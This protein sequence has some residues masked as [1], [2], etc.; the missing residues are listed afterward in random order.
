VNDQFEFS[1]FNTQ[2]DYALALS[3]FTHLYL[4]HIQR[5]LVEMK[6]VLKPNG[7]FFATFF[8]SPLPAYLPDLHHTP[9]QVTTHYDHDPFHYSFVEMQMTAVHADL[10]V[11]LI[12]EFDHP[13]GQK[14][15]R[16][17]HAG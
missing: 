17:T 6:K 1:S 7:V 12:G 8:Q 11:E 5:C 2:F 10:A 3:V 9:G 13:R 16:F 15:L 14:M 4:N